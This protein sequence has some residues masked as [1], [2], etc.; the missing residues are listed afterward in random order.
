MAGSNDRTTER[1]AYQRVTYPPKKG[2]YLLVGNFR[3]EV[4][5]ISRRGIRFLNPEKLKLADWIGATVVLHDG[6]T[7]EI[8]GKIVWTEDHLLGVHLL[9]PLP[10]EQI[11]NEECYLIQEGTGKGVE[12]GLASEATTRKENLKIYLVQHG[13]PVAE[14]VDPD[15]PLSDKGRADVRKTGLFLQ[16]AGISVGTV[17]HSNKTRGVGISYTV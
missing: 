4:V 10:H 3:L 7:H 1:R 16:Q 15:R 14:E 9:N 12:R 2:C 6:S 11:L 17:F 13:E 8:E 5:D